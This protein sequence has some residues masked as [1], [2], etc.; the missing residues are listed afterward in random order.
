MAKRIKTNSFVNVNPSYHFPQRHLTA[1]EMEQKEK[2]ERGVRNRAA[3]RAENC[4]AVTM[5]D[6]DALQASNFWK[7]PW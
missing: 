5:V 3:R 6:R 1:R 2:K 7:R 4:T